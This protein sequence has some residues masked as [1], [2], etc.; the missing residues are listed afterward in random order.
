MAVNIIVNGDFTPLSV[1]QVV[2]CVNRKGIDGVYYGCAGGFSP[3][4][5]EDVKQKSSPLCSAS[6]GGK[7]FLQPRKI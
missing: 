4:A 5:F 7:L 6:M 3:A 1:Q 2:D